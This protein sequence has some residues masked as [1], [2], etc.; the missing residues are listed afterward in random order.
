[1]YPEFEFCK[2]SDL[3]EAAS[4][5][6]QAGDKACVLAGGTDLLVAMR[7]KGLRP[8]V[9]VSIGELGE[10]KETP[11]LQDGRLGIGAATTLHEIER[12]DTVRRVCPVLADAVSTIGSYQ[13]RNRATL[14]GNLANASPA[15][16]SAPAVL[17]L[18]G[19]ME[20][21]SS[22]GSRVVRADSFFAGP[23]RTVMARG[24]ILRRIVIPVPQP[25]TSAVYLKFGPRR[26]M[27][28]AVVGVAVSLVLEGDGYCR[29]A[30]VALGA[31]APIPMRAKSAEQALVGKIDDACIEQAA[32]LAA[33]EANP[34]GDVRASAVYRTHLV[35]VLVKDAVR[36]ALG[37]PRAAGQGQGRHE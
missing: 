20:L 13:V 7:D 15:A 17:V 37:Q 11:A 5:L 29:E 26:A 10:L 25:N 34:I 28:I 18:N 12:S 3:N 8:E 23:G 4:I 32:A 2:P 30:R 36:Q 21:F 24:E 6:A 22:A 9:L 1:M 14:G 16:D 33:A 35:R 27:D 31:V 19:E